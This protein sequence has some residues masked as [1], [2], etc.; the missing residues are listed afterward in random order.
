MLSAASMPSA[1]AGSHFSTC[2]SCLLCWV[3]LAGPWFIL[4]RDGASGGS[5]TSR[6]MD[7]GKS[8]QDAAD[9]PPPASRTNL[10]LD[11]RG[12]VYVAVSDR[13]ANSLRGSGRRD[14]LSACR[15]PA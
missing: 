7:Q 4:R 11:Q 2:C 13:R 8:E 3:P 1:A 5:A 14:Q 6:L 9:L 12:H 15:R 10:A